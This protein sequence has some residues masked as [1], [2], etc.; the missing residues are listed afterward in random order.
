VG[1]GAAAKEPGFS[2]QRLLEGSPLF[3]PTQG[4]G[5]LLLVVRFRR[6][7]G[8][9]AGLCRLDVIMPV[10]EDGLNIFSSVRR[11]LSGFLN[12]FDNRRAET[13][14]IVVGLSI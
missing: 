6:E 5:P 8:L 11:N 3:L 4:A 1:S 12:G 13:L 7:L 2:L 10:V 14:P 9:F